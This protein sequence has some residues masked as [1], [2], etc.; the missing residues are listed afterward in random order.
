M[1]YPIKKINK[2]IKNNKKIRLTAKTESQILPLYFFSPQQLRG[3]KA[4]LY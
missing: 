4:T 1:Y 3:E 2:K